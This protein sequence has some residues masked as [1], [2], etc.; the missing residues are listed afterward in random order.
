MSYQ[1]DS[2]EDLA[3]LADQIQ[4]DDHCTHDRIEHM[5]ACCGTGSIGDSDICVMC[6]DHAEFPLT[7][8]LCLEEQ[9]EPRP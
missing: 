3:H 7:C 1:Y 4:G 5:S 2:Y 8:M 9:A 6:R